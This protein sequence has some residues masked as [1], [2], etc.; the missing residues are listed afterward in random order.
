M[1][2]LRIFPQKSASRRLIF[3]SGILSLAYCLS[4]ILPAQ[5]Q[6]EGDLRLITSPLPINLSAE[7]GKSVS[8][9]LRI[10]NDG[11]TPERLKISLMKFSAYGENGAPQ[12]LDPEPG[13]TFLSW[14]RFTEDVFDVAPGEWKT[15]GMTIDV[16]KEAA[17]G[18]YYAV[19][20]SRADESSDTVDRQTKLAGGTS[21]LV[22]LEAKVKDAKRQAEV[23]EFSADRKFYEFLPATFTVRIKNTGNVHI[24]PHGDIFI[25]REGKKAAFELPVNQGEGK[26]NILPDT[27]REFEVRWSDGFP[28]YEDKVVDGATVRDENGNIVRD[29]VWDWK[30]AAKLRFGKY[31]ASLLLIYDDGQR[32]IPIEGTVTFWVLP[33]RLLLGVVFNFVLIIGLIWYV[34]RLR[35]RLKRLQGE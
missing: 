29:L 15:V 30:D 3:L 17:F 8:S 33:W 6:E 34:V 18:Y 2:T 10:K 21:V 23:A 14:A 31:E 20:F 11:E 22:L 19:V 9:D 12:L 28:V 32:D 1:T 5:A 27:F 13:D 35:R 16:P 26:G 7:P 4:F 24:A 25:G